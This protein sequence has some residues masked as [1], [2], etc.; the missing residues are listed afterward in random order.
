MAARDEPPGPRPSLAAPRL[1]IGRLS[2]PR[3]RLTSELESAINRKLRKVGPEKLDPAK[4]E[5]LLKAMKEL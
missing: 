3:A 1:R 4:A 2:L 5:E